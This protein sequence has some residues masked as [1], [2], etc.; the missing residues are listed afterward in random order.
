MDVVVISKTHRPYRHQN[1]SII[2]YK[3]PWP[4][5]SEASEVE[6]GDVG[7]FYLKFELQC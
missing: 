4:G 7:G 5:R 3:C 1:L 6:G 2:L